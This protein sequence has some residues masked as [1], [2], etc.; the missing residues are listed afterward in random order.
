[1]H[2]VTTT[3]AANRRPRGW[4]RKLAYVLVALALALL[5]M[6]A[7]VRLFWNRPP[8][9]L[10]ERLLHSDLFVPDPVLGWRARPHHVFVHK[11]H[12]GRATTIR[13]NGQGFRDR[14]R[15]PARRLGQ[16]RI[17]VVGDSFVFGWGVE[18][19]ETFVHRLDQQLAGTEVV[20]LGVTGFNLA[21]EHAL[22][23][24]EG[25]AYQPDLVL[26]AFCQN[27][28]CDQRVPRAEEIRRNRQIHAAGFRAFVLR[29]CYLLDL[30]R[31]QCANI[32]PLRHLLQSLG[33]KEADAGYQA[34]DPNLRPALKKYPPE[35]VGDWNRSLT[36]LRAIHDTCKRAGVPLMVAAIPP[37]QAIVPSALTLSL[38]YSRFG[39]TDFD[40][41]KPQK[42][43]GE[44]CQQQGILFLDGTQAI[45][46]LG[47]VAYLDHD[48]HFSAAGHRAFAGAIAAALRTP[49][50]R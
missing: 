13:T 40:L 3:P 32:R 17:L 20:N 22:L 49:R 1:M 21:Q 5:G 23:R 42:A 50:E 33:L 2:S 36:E 9:F 34:L 10:G 47:T 35:L 27:D 26:L 6:E 16:H 41:R 7:M 14:D 28:V 38:A 39:A 11:L 48:M 43:L 29:H 30:L 19:D 18:N 8:R 31:E 46:G 24:Q 25:L 15:D 45:L 4:R 44:F 12:G 37:R